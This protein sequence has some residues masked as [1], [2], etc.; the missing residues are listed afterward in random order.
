M[1]SSVGGLYVREDSAPRAVSVY[2]LC[3]LIRPTL[4]FTS[5]LG[6]EDLLTR[7]TQPTPFRGPHLPQAPTSEGTYGTPSL[8]C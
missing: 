7:V 3:P 6:N 1:T 8:V 4:S 5:P 2:A